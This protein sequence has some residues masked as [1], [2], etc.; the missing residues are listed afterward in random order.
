MELVHRHPPQVYWHQRLRFS[1]CRPQQRQQPLCSF[2]FSPFCLFVASLPSCLH[3]HPPVLLPLQALP[4]V[5]DLQEAL[6]P[7]PS[8][9]VVPLSSRS[10][11]RTLDRT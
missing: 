5:A 8:F 4:F 6:V 9:W 2:P 7:S 10:L 3:W 1:S 11:A